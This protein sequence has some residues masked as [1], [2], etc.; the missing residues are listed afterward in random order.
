MPLVK[1]LRFDWPMSSPQITRMFG[2]FAAWAWASPGAAASPI[3]HRSARVHV[4]ATDCLISGPPPLLVC[5]SLLEG[6][7]RLPVLL[8]VHDRPAL[9]RRLVERL[10]QAADGGLAVV[11]PLPLRVG[12]VDDAHEPRAVSRGG[13][14]EH[15]VVT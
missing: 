3:A 1:M 9:L 8:H 14:L 7:D 2:F 13:P 11:R 5:G 15:L 4:A 6:V 10:V 12:V